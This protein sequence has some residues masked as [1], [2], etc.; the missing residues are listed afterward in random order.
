MRIEAKA[1]LT[2]AALIRSDL[3]AI[4]RIENNVYQFN[5][6]NLSPA[7]LDSLGYSMHKVITSCV[8]FIDLHQAMMN[9]DHSITRRPPLWSGN[10]RSLAT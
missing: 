1:A 3:A 7:E 10:K 5:L 9:L 4:A 2:L 6:D 8:S